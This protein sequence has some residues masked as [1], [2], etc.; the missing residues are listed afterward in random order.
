MSN[1]PGNSATSA[2]IDALVGQAW[3]QHYQGKNADAIQAFQQLVARWPD[4]IDAN[5]G[6]SLTLKADGQKQQAAEAFKKTRALVETAL[7]TQSDD[8]SRFHMLKRMIDQHLA[9]M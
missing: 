5:Y 1:S 3:S 8:N 4:H 9:S 7:E 6:L 2:D